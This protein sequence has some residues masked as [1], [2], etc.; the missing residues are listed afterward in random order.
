MQYTEYTLV[1]KA[2]KQRN[3]WGEVAEGAAIGT[4]AGAAVGGVG[5]GVKGQRRINQFKG[6]PEEIAEIGRRR[7]AEYAARGQ[8]VPKASIR[9]SNHII[10]QFKNE[11]AA[12]T[13]LRNKG[14]AL[15]GGGTALVGGTAALASARHKQKVN[16]ALVA[17]DRPGKTKK[18]RAIEAT[19]A[20]AG[21]GGAAT[22][23]A[24]IPA[25]NISAR[26]AR[27][28]TAAADE[29]TAITRLRGDRNL[30]RY[31]PK[32]RSGGEPRTG[33]I[34]E[35]PSSA[36]QGRAQAAARASYS[37]AEA[38]VHNLSR[39][40]ATK[41]GRAGLG[42]AALGAGGYG[43]AR[44]RAKRKREF[45]KALTKE[46]KEER[47][48]PQL[49]KNPVVTG[50]AGVGAAGTALFAGSRVPYH[51]QRHRSRA[52]EGVSTAAWKEAKEHRAIGDAAMKGMH[53]R[54]STKSGWDAASSYRKGQD[55]L[56]RAHEFSAKS[57]NTKASAIKIANVG[58]KGLIG[59]I[60]GGAAV[61]GGLAYDKHK[62]RKA[63]Q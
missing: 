50:G 10:G 42:V 17:T 43:Y 45:G 2:D 60:A 6:G 58:R 8:K 28:S 25:K 34:A 30:S 33:H 13:K 46:Q 55:A 36:K 7:K 49:P 19:T 26:L 1:S 37:R 29:A 32:V 53:K 47:K 3:R 22:Y 38:G 5:L 9:Q 41:V 59:A 61:G 48:G 62:A 15:L 11:I 20:T 44:H 35:P 24:A 23:A 31:V 63:E 54:N 40:K 4:G 14:A 18:Q 12:G 52:A 27:E 57:T 39:A 16:K 56:T 51:I 21:V